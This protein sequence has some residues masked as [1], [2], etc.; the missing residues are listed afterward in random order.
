MRVRHFVLACLPL[1]AHA[2]S[3][4]SKSSKRELFTFLLSM[5]PT[6]SWARPQAIQWNSGSAGEPWGESDSVEKRSWYTR[7]RSSSRVLP[8]YDQPWDTRGDDRQMFDQPS[9][10]ARV[11]KWDQYDEPR[12]TKGYDD[13]FVR[14]WG[15]LGDNSRYNEEAAQYQRSWGA[16]RSRYNEEPRRGRRHDYTDD[17][18]RY[19]EEPRMGTRRDYTDDRGHYN[20]ES[21]MGRRS[22]YTDD[23][24][25]HNEEPRMGRRR[26]YTDDSGRYEE[27][28]IDR[29]RVITDDRNRDYWETNS[30]VNDY[31]P[32]GSSAYDNLFVRPW[33][34]MGG[35]SR[36]NEETA[37]Y[38]RSWGKT[39]DNE[40]PRA[41]R[42]NNGHWADQGYT[43]GGREIR[44]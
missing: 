27:P 1:Y 39:G 4:R 40:D 34:N 20:E 28:R 12:G 42:R 11:N 35:S 9:G 14:P 30:M 3:L 21:R 43:W 44:R 8:K 19:N 5:K 7:D 26:D 13:L 24:G 32:R 2:T 16:D 18:S 38:Q 6:R 33:G 17:R 25:R 37:M 22:E 29:R 15:S 41:P 10:A 36:Y 31:E 23:R